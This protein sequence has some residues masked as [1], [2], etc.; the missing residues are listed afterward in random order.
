MEFCEDD[1]NRDEAEKLGLLFS[2]PRTTM[3]AV[4]ELKSTIVSQNSAAKAGDSA[5]GTGST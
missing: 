3:D 2:R 1:K 4:D 5:P